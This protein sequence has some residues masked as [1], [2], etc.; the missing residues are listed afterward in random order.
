[1]DN[2]GFE[3][4][5]LREFDFWEPQKD[6]AKEVGLGW[7]Y[8]LTTQLPDKSFT[9]QWNKPIHYCILSGHSPTIP[10]PSN[11]DNK[12]ISFLKTAK[13]LSPHICAWLPLRLP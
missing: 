1:M 5:T 8:F 10:L 4:L 13:R 9:K 2:T 6:R 3:S 11:Q 12:N 7:A